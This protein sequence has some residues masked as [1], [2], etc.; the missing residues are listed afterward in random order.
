[1]ATIIRA[2]PS[3]QSERRFFT[4]MALLL[5]ALVLWGF[6][7]TFYMTPVAPGPVSYVS[8]ESPVRWL[9]MAHGLAFTAWVALY[10]AQ[11]LLVAGRRVDLHRTLVRWR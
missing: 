1:M 6:G 7:P 2:A 3:R 4:A 11:T 8:P 10:L 9:F 5:T